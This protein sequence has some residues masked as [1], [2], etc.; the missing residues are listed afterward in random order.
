[1]SR[2]FKVV[3]LGPNGELAKIHRE[4]RTDAD[5]VDVFAGGFLLKVESEAE[6]EGWVKV[7]NYRSRI[8]PEE[9]AGWVPSWVVGEPIADL[10]QTVSAYSLVWAAARL[11][12]ELSTGYDPVIAAEYLIA[13]FLIENDLDAAAPDLNDDTAFTVKEDRPNHDAVGGYAITTDEWSAFLAGPGAALGWKSPFLRALTMPQM[14]CAAHLTQRDWQAFARLSG[15]TP[16]NPLLPRNLDLFLSRLVG[17]EAAAE[18][19]KRERGNTGLDAPIIEVVRAANEWNAGSPKEKALLAHRAR[20]LADDKGASV[21]VGAVLT[22]CR[23]AL[24]PALRTA[25]KA[26]KLY[27]PGFT[28]SASP[29]EQRW[30]SL[31]K[32]EYEKWK[33]GGWTEHSNPGQNRALAF[34]KATNHGPGKITNPATGE[35]TDWCGAFVAHF[36]KEAGAAPPSGAAAAASWR[37]WGDVAFSTRPPAVVPNGAVV[38]LAGGESDADSVSHVCFFAGWDGTPTSSGWAATRA[39]AS[40]WRGRRWSASSPSARWRTRPSPTTTTS[41]SWRRPSM[42][43]FAVPRKTSRSGTWRTSC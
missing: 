38:T 37:A 21:S 24:D 17:A 1:M 33:A 22:R 19:A 35:I 27:I 10:P 9:R 11:E 32:E 31:A 8:D 28:V 26:V 42:A 15:G 4:P 16:T 43:R 25:D 40:P 3:I 12:L 7:K 20:F 41:K 5:S 30:F 14:R 6:S 2:S 13:L 36:V 18:M 39:T 34:F 29:S 23:A